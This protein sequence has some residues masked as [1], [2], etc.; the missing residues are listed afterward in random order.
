MSGSSKRVIRLGTRESTLALA[1]AELV[2]AAITKG[3]A[4]VEVELVKIVTSGDLSA[5][6]NVP[7]SEGKGMFIKELEHAL[8]AG[9]VDIAV[10]SLKDV[11]TMLSGD[12]PLVAYSRREDPFD[13]LVLPVGVSEVDLSKPIGCSSARRSIQLKTLYPGAAI[14]PYRGNVATRL[15][16]LESGEY[17][18][19][20]LAAAGLARLG[21]ASRASK[22]FTLAEMVPAAG[23]GIIAV[24][25]TR[26]FDARLLDGFSVRESAIAAE[27]ERAFVA[28]CGG[29]CSS[30]IGA[31]AEVDGSDV[32]MTA[33]FSPDG[34]HWAGGEILGN[35]GELDSMAE[36]LAY[37]L[38]RELN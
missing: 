13:C 17:A 11:P 26:D 27:A 14:V 33:L 24:Q 8:A 31:Y 30:P 38:K 12:F 19:T 4:D 32:R 36:R 28:Y 1:Q 21:L 37:E 25:A 34:E 29:D 23:Q 3:N 9:Q 6:A 2:A 10:H 20:V 22:R 7:L 5:P 18:A 15:S 35:T 16:K